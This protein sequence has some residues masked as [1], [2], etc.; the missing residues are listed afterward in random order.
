MEINLF[1]A[2]LTE[3][4]HTSMKLRALSCSFDSMKF[5]DFLKTKL[6]DAAVSLRGKK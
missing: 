5:P 6:Q 2:S 3:V 4:A 1:Y